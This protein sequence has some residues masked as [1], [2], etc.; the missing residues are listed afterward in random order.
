MQ[1]GT[2]VRNCLGAG[3]FARQ[4]L[5]RVAR[6]QL[7]QTKNQHGYEHQCWYHGDEAAHEVGEHEA[8]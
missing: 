8:V 3:V 2:N 4:Y 1:F 5:G 6:Q 7:L